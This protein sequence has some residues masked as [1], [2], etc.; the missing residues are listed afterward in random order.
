MDL[1]R[2]KPAILVVALVLFLGGCTT[3][4]MALGVQSSPPPARGAGQANAA[5]RPLPRMAN[6]TQVSLVA[7]TYN[8]GVISANSVEIVGAGP[9]HTII[10]GDLRIT[11]NNVVIRGVRI[12]GD[13][14]IQGNNN[15]LVGVAVGGTVHSSGRNNR[16]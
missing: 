13:V 8:G 10:R 9:A 16:W 5:V 2:L 15:S 12:S 4:D 14:I 1:K 11:G 7:A 3:L 6:N